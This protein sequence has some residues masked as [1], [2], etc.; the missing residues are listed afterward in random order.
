MKKSLIA[1]AVLA[2]SGAAMAQSSVTLFGVADAGVTFVDGARNWTGLT[3]GNQLTSRI[4]FRGTEDL[5]GGLKANFNLESGDND[6]A[7]GSSTVAFSRAAWVGLSGNFGAIRV[8]RI[9]SVGTQATAAFDFNGI[10]TTSSSRANNTGLN[11]VTWYGSSRRSNQFQYDTPAFGGL[12]AGLG[13]VL[14]GDNGGKSYTQARVNYANGPLAIALVGESAHSAANRTAWGLHGSYNLGV[15]K[16]GLGYDVAETTA[17]GKGV[18]LGVTAPIGAA[19]IGAQYT[20]NST[21]DDSALELFANYAFSKRTQ[22]YFD[23]VRVNKNVGADV[24]RWG[25]GIQ[26]NF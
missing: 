10:S 16:L 19:N 7:V 23:T 24:T 21:T 6:L 14:S 1:L 12:T 2:A 26:H 11:P 17:L 13:V 20:K 3:S 22:V 15:V 9:S 8:G 25:V 18:T 5:G 4:G